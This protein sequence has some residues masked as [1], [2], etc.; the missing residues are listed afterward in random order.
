MKNGKSIWQKTIEQKNYPQLSSTIKREAVV[1]G[2]G[3]AGIL[4]AYF[5][6]S[7]GV[8]VAVLEADRVGSGQTANTTAKITSQHGA[9][10]HRLIAWFGEDGAGE[11]ALR[12]QK[13]IEDYAQIISKERI[14]CDFQRLPAYL[15]TKKQRQVLK[16]EEAAARSLGVPCRFHNETEL[17]FE[18]G[19]ALEFENQAQFHPL[20]FLTALGEK[21]EIY[22]K[23]P[24][25]KVEGKRIFTPRGGVLAGTIVFA[26][27]YPFINRPGYYF[28]RMHQ[29]RSYAAALEN[30]Q[31]LK[32]MYYGIDAD[33]GWSFRCAREKLVMGGCNHR[34][35]MIPGEDPYRQL[36]KQA[37][38]LWPESRISDC[39]SAQDCM[40]ADHIPYIGKFSHKTP[41]W[42]VATGFNKWGMTHSMVSAR[43]LT[44]KILDRSAGKKSIFSPR[45]F[46]WSRGTAAMLKDG[47]I[48]GKNLF[49]AWAGAAPK[50]PHLGCRLNWNPYEKKWECQCHG[51]RFDE[52]GALL[53][54][55]SQTDL[56]RKGVKK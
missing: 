46:K 42:Y 27:H 32:G 28:M 45:R 13:A 34:T 40:T 16:Q 21:L 26:T 9:V 47:A 4:T 5:L 41:D 19:G 37:K 22:E 39:W 33:F 55:P 38:I 49:L 12:N 17:P 1:V 3:L 25:L 50:C 44:E 29:E 11:Y 24:V 15:Y 35:G 18:I 30:A 36:S 7:R 48:S 52:D 20:K 23:T 14:D 31:P 51:S 6:Q 8:D 10:Y 43:L 53:A 2:G 56:L 54:G